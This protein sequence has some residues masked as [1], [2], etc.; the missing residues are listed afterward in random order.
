MHDSRMSA[1]KVF[2]S[3]SH[4]SEEHGERVLALSDRLR[5]DGIETS[6]DQYLNGSPQ[7]GWPRW[8]LDQLDLA[9]Y[10][11]VV[12][13]EAYYRRFRGH[14]EPGQG[15][16]VDFEGLLVTQQI[17]D[18]RSKTLRFVPVF[19]SAPDEAWIPEPLRSVNYYALSSEAH[20]QRLYDFLLMQAG[21]DPPPV[22]AP[23]IR[24]RR[25]GIPLSF[26]D[27]AP[28]HKHDS[29]ELL[30]ADTSPS[31]VPPGLHTKSHADESIIATDRQPTAQA[32]SRDGDQFPSDGFT[33][34]AVCREQDLI[35]FKCY[36]ELAPAGVHVLRLRQPGLIETL[37]RQK[38]HNTS[39]D[40]DFG[41]MLFRLAIP[42]ELKVAARQLERI[43]LVLDRATAQLPW[44]MILADVPNGA[45]E[46]LPMA[47]RTPIVRQ[48]G[49]SP[50][51]GQKRPVAERCAFVVGN[52]SV[53][54]FGAGFPDPRNPDWL[55]DPPALP[56]AEA[57]AVAV[58]AVLEGLNYRVVQ[59]IGDHQTASE[60]LAQLYRQP[61]HIVHVSAHGVFDL[62]HR[63]GRR[64]SGIALSDGLLRTAAEVAAMETVPELMYLNCCHLGEADAT[65]REGNKLATSV[66]SE[67]IA[68]GVRCV[69]VAG[70]SVDDQQAQ[71]FGET[72]YRGLL[73]QRLPFGDAVHQ[74]RRAVWER[75]SD[76]ITWGAFQA[77][78]NPAWRPEG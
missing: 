38:I 13:T 55:G 78:G 39:W 27:L 69:V 20:Y 22:G 74:G 1:P 77:Y 12:C 2:V 59:A 40:P 26:D 44:E 23:K 73:Q 43:V 10:V 21:V 11:L 57:E 62:L 41:R 48:F 28:S 70:W 7:Q 67:L 71:L 63:D 52:P 32:P 54:H 17:Y 34:I 42:D 58:A 51:A 72:F 25:K 33:R 61:Y 18:S 53:V 37:V 31:V 15:K 47:V 64:R 16:G 4:D 29:S 68:I 65:F 56:G 36:S 49:S 30:P 24:A 8:M 14:E 3:Y 45:G 5:T 60:V 66:A 75:R 35:Q 76:D 50:M 19:L 9:N 46:L 6:L